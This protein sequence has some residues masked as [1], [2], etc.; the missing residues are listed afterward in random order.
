[1][2]LNIHNYDSSFYLGIYFNIDLNFS[3][4]FNY[5]FTDFSNEM[6]KFELKCS[7]CQPG[8]YLNNNETCEK[9]NYDITIIFNNKIN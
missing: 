7:Y 8:Y 1:M 9:L 2:S 4:Y 6:E 3:N 5:I